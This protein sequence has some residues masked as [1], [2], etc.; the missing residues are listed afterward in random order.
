MKYFSFAFIFL[1]FSLMLEGGEWEEGFVERLDNIE[2]GQELS[3]LS[4]ELAFE[5]IS[6]EARDG[7]LIKNELRA[8]WPQQ[9]AIDE[10]I[11]IMARHGDHLISGEG[12]KLAMLKF[13]GV[14]MSGKKA[15]ELKE[16]FKYS[17]L[18]LRKVLMEKKKGDEVAAAINKF[19]LYKFLD[20][21]NVASLEASAAEFVS[22]LSGSKT[23]YG[24]NQ[25]LSLFVALVKS[26]ESEVAS[27]EIVMDSISTLAFYKELPSK[28]AELIHSYIETYAGALG[29]LA[30]EALK[31]RIAEINGI[32]K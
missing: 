12:A 5:I 28:Y 24:D 3:K 23:L 7:P 16:I 26:V 31:A 6:F 9:Q 25:L 13:K 14:G 22:M 15:S 20:D 19:L 27:I 29:P 10:K 21:E 18:E 17:A 2:N 11:L 4:K 1:T 30:Q 8:D 32:E